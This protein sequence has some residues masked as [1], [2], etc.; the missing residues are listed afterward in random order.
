[1]REHEFVGDVLG[2]A[3]EGG[4]ALGLFPRAAS[5]DRDGIGVGLEFEA[6]MLD[7]GQIHRERE[8]VGG[9]I[10]LVGGLEGRAEI[11]R[12][13]GRLETYHAVVFT[14]SNAVRFFTRAHEEI[15]GRGVGVT[16]GTRMF[17]IGERTAEEALRAGYPVHLIASGRSDAETLLGELV[18]LLSN[19]GERVLIPRSR[20]AAT[21]I[22]DGLRAAG[23]EVDSIA[24]Y[25][26]RRP[27]IDE[28]DL[29][30]RLRNGELV[31]LT[32][33]SPSTVDNFLACM[34]SRAKPAADL[35]TVGH[36]SSLL[37]QLGNAAWRAGR[38]L[39][40]DFESHQFLDDPQ[41]AQY[42]T[43][44]EYRAPWLLPKIAD[45]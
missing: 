32:F 5:G 2:F 41:A 45:V 28:E 40:F 14:S 6:G 27:S 1:M 26:N 13:L 31:A 29:R 33:T 30:A 36:P 24:F 12:V 15:R 22:A 35:E 7:A 3:V 23:V 8:T 16:A 11:A 44:P 38:T 43:R 37:C 10:Q 20:I 18:P 19:A 25:E 42:L 39:K 9:F 4:P 17:C 34:A 21:K